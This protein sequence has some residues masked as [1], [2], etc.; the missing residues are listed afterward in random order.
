MGSL[1][2]DYIDNTIII[3]NIKSLRSNQISQLRFWGFKKHTDNSYELFTDNPSIKLAKV[4]SYFNK[5]NLN[6]CLLEPCNNYITKINNQKKFFEETKTLGREYKD[7]VFNQQLFSE[8]CDFIKNNID[9]KLKE[10]QL[11]SAYHL[12]LVK[13][14]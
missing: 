3:G 2:I 4:L 1:T 13:N 11:K 12:Y 6:Y 8:F 10:H 9:R 14:G 5:E 7:G